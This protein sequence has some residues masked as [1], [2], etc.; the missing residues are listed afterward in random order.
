MGLALVIFSALPDIH[1]MIEKVKNEQ[2]FS[3]YDFEIIF[4]YLK[5]R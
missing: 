1:V 3:K 4:K 2:T 5:A